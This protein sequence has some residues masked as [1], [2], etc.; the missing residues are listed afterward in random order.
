MPWLINEDAALKKK[1]QG[2]TVFDGN[3]PNGRPV[4]VRYR[5]P[6]VE[7]ADLTF[8]IIIITHNGWYPAN[9]REHRGF[10]QLPY[11]PEGQPT[12]WDDTVQPAPSFD[13]N[14]SPYYSYYPIPYN[15]DYVV[16]VYSRIMHE[17]TIPLVSALSQYDRLHPKFG[18]LD[19]PQ[20]GTKR[21]MQLLGGPSLQSG[22][23]NN[24][25]RI[26]WVDFLVRVF[27]ELVPPMAN[28]VLANRINLDLSVYADTSDLT[29][30]EL[31]ESHAYISTGVSSAWNV[32]QI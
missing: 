2:L 25:K 13:P 11:A 30:K 31:T 17:H 7:P 20:D 6:E 12:W 22:K 3:A 26:F 14:D 23:D 24:G 19:I 4:P 5:L 18:F 29:T 28:Y 8:P 15:F 32:S 21:T 16:T 10:T 9:D 1:L 27:S